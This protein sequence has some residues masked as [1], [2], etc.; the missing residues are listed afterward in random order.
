MPTIAK[1]RIV[2]SVSPNSL[3]EEAKPL[4]SSAISWNQGDLLY[5]DTVNNLIK[6][7]ASDAN[8]ATILGIAR[9]SIVSG[10]PV[11]PYQGTA[12]DAAQAIENLGGPQFGVVAKMLL[13]SG[14]AFIPGGAVY[15]GGDAQTVSSAG[16]NSVGV[17]QGPALT[18][19]SG[20][21]GEVA[22]LCYL[23]KNM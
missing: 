10:K 23:T 15:Y 13:K 1:N 17:Y 7:L 11:S 18:A 14:D 20:S 22:L 16:T 8:A 5:L 3:F 2:R 19:A 4:I 21:E 6:P 12:V 9:Q